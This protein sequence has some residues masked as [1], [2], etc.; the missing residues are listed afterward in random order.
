[1]SVPD[2]VFAWNLCL[3]ASK[4]WAGVVCEWVCSSVQKAARLTAAA[5]AAANEAVCAQTPANV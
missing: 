5:A 1:M 2:I 4:Q 3:C